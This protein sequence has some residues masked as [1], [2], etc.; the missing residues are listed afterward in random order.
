MKHLLLSIVIISRNEE[1]YIE[2]CLNSI[3]V[4]KEDKSIEIVLVDSNSVDQ[5]VN[6]AKATSIPDQIIKIVDSNI[7]TAAL[8]RMIGAK[9]SNG[10]Y[11]LFI[12]GDMEVNL[13]TVEKCL[14]VLRFKDETVVGITGERT[15]YFYKNNVL[16]GKKEDCLKIEPNTKI[17]E[18]GGAVLFRSDIFNEVGCYDPSIINGEEEEFYSRI[19]KKGK[20]V[21][22]IKDTLVIHHTNYQNALAK[23]IYLFVIPKNP[24]FGQALRASILNRHI[25]FF[26]IKHYVFFLSFFLDIVSLVVYG[27]GTSIIAVALIQLIV[28]VGNYVY[29]EKRPWF[30]IVNKLRIFYLFYGLFKYERSVDYQLE[31]MNAS[32]NEGSSD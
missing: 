1:K 31:Y 21:I 30:Y 24:G 26:I 27:S 12:D 23:F 13:T 10:K 5:T 3:G 32:N 18:F 25:W 8:G 6:I 22:G 17:R 7:Y 19:I 28:L 29:Y 14:K 9:H 20:Y 4:L 2:K 11:T 15:D 16:I